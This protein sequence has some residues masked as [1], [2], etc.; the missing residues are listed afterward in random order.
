MSEQRFSF[1]NN[2]TGWIVFLISAFT[3]LSTIEPTT[4]LWDCGEFIAASYKLEVVHPP[5]APFFLML[6][7]LFSMFAPSPEWVPRIINGV[8]A[9]A[10]AF[11]VLFLF[12]TITALARKIVISD[13]RNIKTGELIGVLGSGIV[14][15]LAFNF[16]DTFWFSAVEGEVYALSSFFMALVFWLML[17]WERR[18]ENPD[19]LR[20]IVLI[21]Y[22]IGLSIGVHLLS[23]LVIPALVYV[24][25]FKYRDFNFKGIV[26][27]GVAGLLILGAVNIGVIQWLPEIASEFEALFVNTFGF[28]FWSGIFFTVLLLLGL[29]IYGLHWSRKKQKKALNFGLSAL[30][31][32]LMGYSSYAMVVIRSNANPSIDMNNPESVFNLTSYIKREQY[33]TRPIFFGPYFTAGITR[34]EKGEMRYRKGK[35]RYLEIGHKRIP[36]FDPAHKTI[37]PRMWDNTRKDRM[38]YYRRWENLSE[39]EKPTFAQNLHFFFTYQLG[40]MYWRYFAWNFI[41]RQN[42]EQG[43]ENEFNNGNWI[44]GIPFIDKNLSPAGP[45]QDLPGTMKNDRAKNKLYALPFVLGLLGLFFHL[46]RDKKSAFYTFVFFFMTGIGLVIYS[47]NPPYEP[48]ERDY[49]LVGSFYVFAV[50]IGLGVLSVRELLRKY[51]SA[52]VSGVAATLICLLLVPALM[53]REEWDDHDRSE[54][55]MPRNIAINYL[56][57]CDSNAVLITNGDN[58]TYPIWYLQEVEGI[59]TDV[60]ALNF[61]LLNTGWYANNLRKPANKSPGL[62][63]SLA[64]EKIVEGTRNYIIH[65]ENPALG[66]DMNKFYDVKEIIGFIGSD[67]PRTR[68]QGNEGQKFDYYPTNKFFVPAD[69]AKVLKNGL[70]S[71]EYKNRIVD[72]MKFTYHGQTMMKNIMLLLDLI[73]TTGWERPICFAVTSGSDP[74]N[75]LQ[76]YFRMDGM[77]YTL[78]PVKKKKN[79]PDPQTGWINPEKMY[80]NV[81]HEFKWGNLPDKDLYIDG[82]LM[83][84][85]RHYRNVFARLAE[86]LINDGKKEKAIK[87]LDRCVKVLPEKNIPYGFL[88]FSIVE[89]Y[90]KAGAADK[91]MKYGKR[92]V[93]IYVDELEYYLDL[94][95][96]DRKVVD[97]EIQRKF[98]ALQQLQQFARQNKQK[99]FAKEVEEDYKKLSNRYFQFK[100]TR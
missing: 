92:L 44:S 59:R 29:I 8:S 48:R 51:F 19:S 89:E 15:A 87:V 3:I 37:F 2:L 53:A 97:K 10:S 38:R 90:Y 54:R 86:A 6:N 26:I 99:E 93:R 63:F 4:S 47:N 84:Q 16:S 77:V 18:A 91:G 69:K 14:G 12:W 20:W 72:R 61:S 85:L 42:G 71:P 31:V 94:E 34:Y 39:G 88:F 30:L 83:R 43:F 11:A 50:W 56:Q 65:R 62:K 82:V 60:R 17:K 35:D 23:L 52:P 45:Q 98:Y 32:I 21:A 67:D 75:G 74:Y 55:F 76:D 95:S 13:P 81:M 96:S 40:H 41:G 1:L 73:A 24:F 68:L 80:H 33:G 78:T 58:E 66:L 57:S 79:D 5:G 9:M 100:E 64:P 70:V 49:V 36:V 7:R 22:F 46:K 25:Y 27:A 28:P